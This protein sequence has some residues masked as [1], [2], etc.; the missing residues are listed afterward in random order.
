MLLPFSNDTFK[1]NVQRPLGMLSPVAPP[2]LRQRVHHSGQVDDEEE[3]QV[4]KPKKRRMKKL[5]HKKRIGAVA[6]SEEVP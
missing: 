5:K 2:R 4:L 6:P 1:L 3:K